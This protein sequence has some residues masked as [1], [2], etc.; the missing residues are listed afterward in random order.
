MS[1]KKAARL[2][3]NVALKYQFYK[4]NAALLAFLTT[5]YYLCRQIAA[6]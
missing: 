2:Y 6:H 1:A 3:Y 5:L 4:I